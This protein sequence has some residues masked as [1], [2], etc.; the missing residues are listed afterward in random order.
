[1]DVDIISMSWSFSEKDCKENSNQFQTF[2]RA[3]NIQ[4]NE[5][6]FE[7]DKNASPGVNNIS[8]QRPRLF[9]AA[10]HNDPDKKRAEELKDFE[11]L[12]AS[13]QVQTFEIATIEQNQEMKEKKGTILNHVFPFP[14]NKIPITLQEGVTT[15]DNCGNSFS[16][17]IAAGCAALILYTIEIVLRFDEFC[18][19]VAKNP[20]QYKDQK[21]LLEAK[22]KLEGCGDLGR[23]ENRV[24]VGKSRL[25]KAKT[26]QGMMS[27]LKKFYPAP[28]D[29]TD[30]ARVG[31][32]FAGPEEN[33]G[34][35]KTMDHIRKVVDRFFS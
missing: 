5:E 35:F 23:M 12:P 22:M 14:G 26:F 19:Q 28:E 33:N 21:A 25:K 29:R 4:A 20:E 31:T 10:S 34:E 30:P 8:S 27:I 1:M 3:L 24:Q 13:H 2:K 18:V 15:T 9:F 32:L 6:P 16:T 17:A 11:F 7:S